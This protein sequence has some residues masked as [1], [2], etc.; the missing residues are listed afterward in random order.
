MSRIIPEELSK[1]RNLHFLI[2]SAV[3]IVVVP[4][5]DHVKFLES[6]VKY[7]V[8]HLILVPPQ[9]VLLCKHPATKKY[10][11]S[12]VRFCLSGAAPLSAEL[13]E[14]LIKVLPN[15]SIGQGYGMTETC[16]TVSMIPASQH[17]GT[18]GSGGQLLPGMKARIVKED[19]TLAKCGEQGELVVTGPSIALGYANN[20][21]ATKASFFDGWVRTGDE[22]IINEKS[23]LFV[24]DRLKEIMKVRGFQVAPAELEGHLLMHP[25]VSDTCVVGVP[26]E[27]SGEIP[28]AFVALHHSAVKRAASNP[29]EAD[30]IKADLIKHV[31]DHKINYKWLAGGVEFVDII[32]KNPSGKLLRRLLR[33]KAKELRAIKKG[34]IRARL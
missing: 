20:A 26:D 29:G 1:F 24:V 15:A 10:D 5:F 12:H 22:V 28:L 3:S 2:F 31:A 9:V 21:E 8:A 27:Y 14:Q 25:D 30:N 19:G 32:P 33:D 6:V 34:V 7:R 13:T 11:L 17:I 18:L 4:K 23:E 16:T